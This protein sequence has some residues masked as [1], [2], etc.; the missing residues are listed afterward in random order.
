[1]TNETIKVQALRWLF[2]KPLP[3]VISLVMN[4]VLAYTINKLWENQQ[5]LQ[6]QMFELQN[7]VIKENTKAFIEFNYKNR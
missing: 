5:Q 6:S 4:I 2:E 3:I 1:M 7:T